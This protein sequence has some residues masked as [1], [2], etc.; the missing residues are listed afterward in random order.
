[1]SRTRHIWDCLPVKTIRRLFTDSRVGSRIG[2]ADVVAAFKA[3]DPAKRRDL[4]VV[5]DFFWHVGPDIALKNWV[6]RG[7]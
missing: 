3:M 2:P 1:M 5:A 4:G 7:V 6:W